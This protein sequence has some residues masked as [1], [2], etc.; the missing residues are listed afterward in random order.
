MPLSERKRG[1]GNGSLKGRLLR[2]VDVH[3]LAIV[4]YAPFAGCT[5]NLVS[6]LAYRS[7]LYWIMSGF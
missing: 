5:D 6:C 3:G 2:L 7:L 1:R 4:P